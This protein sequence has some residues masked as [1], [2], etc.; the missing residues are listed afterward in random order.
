MN[1]FTV[2]YIIKL[3]YNKEFEYKIGSGCQF[4]SV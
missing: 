4:E 2:L 3:Q 1:K